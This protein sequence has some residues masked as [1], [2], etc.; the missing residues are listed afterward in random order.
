MAGYRNRFIQLFHQIGKF[1]P[2]NILTGITGQRMILPV[3]HLVSD[4]E[5]P[6]IKH[7]YPIKNSHQFELDLDYLLTYYE[8]LSFHELLEIIQFGRTISKNYFLLS[9]DDG[10]REFNDVIAPVLIKKG[11]PAICFLNCDFIDNKDLFYR[12]KASILIEELILRKIINTRSEIQRVLK[13]IPGSD[14]RAQLL[15][16]TYGERYL[17][18]KIADLIDLSYKSFLKKEKPYLTSEQIK[19]LIAKGFHFGA[20][21]KDHPDYASLT[22]EEQLDQTQG[23]MRAVQELF[24]LD[25][26]LFAFPFTDYG[27]SATFFEKIFQKGDGVDL[28]FGSA[29]L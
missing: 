22:L 12:Y 27:V 20:H 24:S 5:L 13:E 7:L 18:D 29:G 15:Q 2:N 17:L 26:G 1:I 19:S 23:S 16:I 8:P 6:H 9:F 25:Y 10:L 14:M 21:S 11:V 28:T 4:H 3:Y